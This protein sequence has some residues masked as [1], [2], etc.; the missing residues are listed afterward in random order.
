MRSAV[1]TGRLP[2]LIL[3][4]GFSLSLSVVAYL[5][6]QNWQYKQDRFLDQH[7]SVVATAYHASVDSYALATRI[8]VA[9]TLL[10]PEVIATFAR[11][12]DG[13]AAARGQLY[14]LLARTYDDLVKRGIRQLHF[15]TATGHSYLRFHALDKFGDPLFDVRPSLRIANTEH[16]VVFGF[17]PG[18]IT[19]GFRYVFPLFDGERHLGGVETSVTFH[20]I[21]ETMARIAPGREYAFVLRR[22]SVEGVVFKD[23]RNLYV[24]WATNHDYFV[25]DPDLKLPNSPPPATPRMRALDAALASDARV[26]SGMAAGKRFTLPIALHGEFWAASLIP[27]S[28]VTDRQVAYVVSYVP[29]PYLGDLRWEFQRSLAI[30]ALLLAMLFFFAHRLWQMQHQQSREADRLRTITNTIADG[31]YVLDAHGRVTLVNPAFTEILGFRPDEVIGKTGHDLFHAHNREG[32]PVS[33]EQCPIYSSVRAG[34]SFWGEEIFRTR[35]GVCLEVEAAGRPILDGNG[36]PSGS[37]VTAFRDISSRKAAEAALLEAKQAAEA[38]NLAKSRFLAT[39]S[40]E[41]R[42]PLNGVLGM[43]QLLLSGPTSQAETKEYGRIILNSGQTLLTLLND[44][45]DLSKI[46]AGRIDL[47]NGVIEPEQILRE[48]AALF[49][50]T[51]ADKGL[52]ISIEWQAPSQGIGHRYRGDPHR[53][54]QMLSNLTGNA[55]KFTHHGEVRLTARETGC[56]DDACTLEFSVSD[57]GIGIDADKLDRL[58][59]PFSQVDASITREFSGT[60]LGLSI[61]RNLAQLMGGTI[62]VDSI[63]GQGSRFWFSVVL[64]PLAADTD[65]RKNVRKSTDSPAQELSA[66]KLRGRVL[67]VEDNRTNRLIIS[68]LLDKLGLTVE[69]AEDGRQAAERILD[70]ADLPLPDL[71]LMDVQMP[72]LDGYGA[73]ARIRQWENE[74]SRPRMPIVALTANVYTE[75]RERCLAAGMDDYLAKPVDI[76][77][78]RTVLAKFLPHQSAAAVANRPTPIHP[79]DPGQVVPLLKELMSLLEQGKFNAVSV[80]EKLSEAIQ[81]TDLAA[82]F[83]IVERYMHD[84]QFAGALREIKIIAAAHDWSIEET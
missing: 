4:A 55:V 64:E 30:A 77:I 76:Q 54:R 66:T 84:M 26:A 48:I 6:H 35:D 57:T 1:R 53:L 65:S 33:I 75:D 24:P 71:I 80:F 28:D 82:D 40:H 72:G 8:L 43:A 52:A 41:I 17:E 49:A 60:G 79:A 59:K 47:E 12:V 67:V 36:R 50:G 58:F 5:L 31:L 51:A 13:D 73:T 11:G 56:S 39:M 44:I 63:P 2:A 70:S 3:L 18:R 45:L 32:I 37:S 7:A 19:S 81:D 25:E 15:H 61:V 62:G 83:A 69:T 38:A 22:D 16:R 14:R 46:E 10:R 9:E 74:H 20:S 27:V 68:T 21:R 34:Q 78:L 29:A 23:T 42:T